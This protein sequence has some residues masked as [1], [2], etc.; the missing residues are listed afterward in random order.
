MSPAMPG[1]R[2]RSPSLGAP[3]AHLSAS[4]CLLMFSCG[5]FSFMLLPPSLPSSATEPGNYVENAVS[6]WE[7]KVIQE[8]FLEEAVLL[9]QEVSC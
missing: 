1:P 9:P 8:G 7:L 4:C 2:L 3:A 6:L 5:A